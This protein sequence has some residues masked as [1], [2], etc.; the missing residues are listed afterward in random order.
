MRPGLSHAWGWPV[1]CT[2]MEPGGERSL[3]GG[4]GQ[5][6]P[7]H[8]EMRPQPRSSCSS[9]AQGL[10]TQLPLTPTPCPTGI[11]FYT[12]GELAGHHPCGPASLTPTSSPHVA[13][14]SNVP[15]ETSHRRHCGACGARWALCCHV[16]AQARCLLPFSVLLL[17]PKLLWVLFASSGPWG[18]FLCLQQCRPSVTGDRPRHREDKKTCPGSQR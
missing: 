9:P 8:W 4:C 12:C 15:D 18:H 6:E 17:S 14:D 3:L 5:R 13:K 7:G 10:T 2:P 16:P 11:C 1:H